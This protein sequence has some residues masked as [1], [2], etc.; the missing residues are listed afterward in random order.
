METVDNKIPVW[1]NK[2]KHGSI[3]WNVTLGS[4]KYTLFP[5][6]Y[7]REGEK[8]PKFNLSISNSGPAQANAADEG[9]PF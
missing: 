5:N 1:E 6:K 4:K 7:W 2:D 9:L 3:Y 8:Q